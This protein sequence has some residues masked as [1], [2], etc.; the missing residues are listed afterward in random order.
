MYTIGRLQSG[1]NWTAVDLGA[2]A[3]AGRRL[4]LD[5]AYGTDSNVSGTGF[6]F[7]EVTITNFFEQVADQQSDVCP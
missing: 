7:D 4:Y 1:G 2:A 6:W 3:R 5:V